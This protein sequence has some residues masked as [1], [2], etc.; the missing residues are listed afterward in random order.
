MSQMEDYR[1]EGRIRWF[2]AWT[3]VGLVSVALY[4][5]TRFGIGNADDFMPLRP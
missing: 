2:L 4:H 1:F 3:G 5:V